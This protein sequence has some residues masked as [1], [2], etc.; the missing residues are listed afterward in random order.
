MAGEGRDEALKRPRGFWGVPRERGM[1]VRNGKCE[2]TFVFGY[3]N[4]DSA[5]R[6][7]WVISITVTSPPPWEM[8]GGSHG[9]G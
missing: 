6:L 3:V 8:R 7:K 9:V 2:W 1:G 4:L 5:V